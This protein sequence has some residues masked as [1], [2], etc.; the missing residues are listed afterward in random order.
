MVEYANGEP[1]F[2]PRGS[3]SKRSRV[4]TG[5]VG[6]TLFPEEDRA[7][8]GGSP[9]RV[10]HVGRDNARSAAMSVSLRRC[11]VAVT[12]PRGAFVGCVL[13]AN[14][15]PPARAAKPWKR[16]CRIRA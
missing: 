12:Y 16:D 5:S 14:V 1:W 10:G 15:V 9:G 13:V 4:T 6:E 7:G 2:A 11:T 3:A 8:G